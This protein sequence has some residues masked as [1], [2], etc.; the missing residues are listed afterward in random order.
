MKEVVD[1]FESG[2]GEFFT[3]PSVFA[4]KLKAIR[5]VLFD[6]DGVF[7]DGFK[8]GEEGSLFSEVD[9]MGT[10]MLRYA[11]W[12]QHGKQPYVA[13]VTGEENPPSQQLAQREHFH[14][15]YVKAKNKVKSLEHFCQ[16]HKLKPGEI[17]FFFDDVL[18]LEVARQ[19]GARVMIARPATVLLQ[20]FAKSHDMVDYLTGC[21]GSSH[22]L[23]EG[24]EMVIGMMGQFEAVIRERMVFSTDYQQYLEERQEIATVVEQGG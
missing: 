5:A 6:W 10:N 11:L 12:K 20:S 17:L 24:C 1:L 2:G 21:A 23:R 3:P 18:D 15:V 7:N 9:A 4:A 22:G 13:V 8:K 16:A 19:C 14:G